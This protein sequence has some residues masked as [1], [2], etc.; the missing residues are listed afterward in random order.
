MKSFIFIVGFILISLNCAI[1]LTLQDYAVHNML[2]SNA[3]I[4]LSVGLIYL[5]L[6]S[7]VGD[8][9]KIGLTIFFG[10]TGILRFIFALLSEESLRSNYSFLLFMII[11]SFELI[12][13]AVAKALRN[14]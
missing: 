6:S 13:F 12:L 14:K 5:L 2:F 4:A 3:S 10:L 11:L 7:K 1:G 9:M 8:G